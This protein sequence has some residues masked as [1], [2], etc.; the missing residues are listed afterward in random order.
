MGPA[1]CY[2]CCRWAHHVMGGSWRR[3]HTTPAGGLVPWCCRHQHNVYAWCIGAIDGACP[4]AL[5]MVVWPHS[6]FGQLS[7]QLCFR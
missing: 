7:W 2:P 6:F 3:V 5:P 1:V 4:V